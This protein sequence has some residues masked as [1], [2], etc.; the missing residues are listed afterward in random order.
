MNG[1]VDVSGGVI[2]VIYENP[3]NCNFHGRTQISCSLVMKNP[4]FF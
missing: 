3:N 1:L 4:H 2:A